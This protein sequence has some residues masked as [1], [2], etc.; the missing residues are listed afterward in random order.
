VSVRVGLVLPTREA[1]MAADPSVRRLIDLAVR[2]ERSGFDSVWAGDAPFARPR[3]EP[4]TLLAAV[5]ASTDRVT[6]GTA[7]VLPVL[8]HPLLFAH[9]VATVDRVAE[10]RFVLGVGAGWMQSEFDAVGA[11]FGQRVGRLL[12]TIEICRMMWQASSEPEPGPVVFHGRYWSFED[13][14]LFPPPSR[15]QGPPVWLGGASEGAIRRAAT[16]FDGWFPT[17]PSVEA[18]AAGWRVASDAAGEAGRSTDELDAAVYLTVNLGSD[19]AKAIAET[20]RYALGY[21]GIPLDVMRGAQSY[22]VGGP[23]ECAE[24][25]RA[26]AQAGARHLV[27]RFA[28]L[29]PEPQLDTVAERLLPALQA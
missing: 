15:P 18:F 21:Y 20:E 4:L 22:F 16:R 14:S 27:L 19:R 2:A 1:A 28:T 13:I 24:W 11:P 23:D 6:V 17:P 8:R 10:G 7:I 26:F 29:D 5:A 9:A 25:L 12:E 3:F